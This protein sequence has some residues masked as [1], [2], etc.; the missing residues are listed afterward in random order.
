MKNRGTTAPAWWAGR[1]ASVSCKTN[2]DS[3]VEVR[4]VSYPEPS[5]E[6]RPRISY[7]T[8]S[9]ATVSWASSTEPAY[10]ELLLSKE[11]SNRPPAKPKFVSRALADGDDDV[12]VYAGRG[13]RTNLTNLESGT[14]YKVTVC[15]QRKGKVVRLPPVTFETATRDG[16]FMV[17][18]SHGTRWQPAWQPTEMHR[19][20]AAEWLRSNLPFFLEEP[21]AP[22]AAVPAAAA[23]MAEKLPAASAGNADSEKEVAARSGVVPAAAAATQEQKALASASAPSASSAKKE[24]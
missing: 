4:E 1:A 14:T 5:W 7:V 12:L 18:S 15:E 19:I 20:G 2:A 8:C 17:Q 22:V 13:T 6:K 3:M 11:S 9:T 21:S 24:T 10:F 23:A 16:H